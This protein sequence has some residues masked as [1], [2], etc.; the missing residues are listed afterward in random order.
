MSNSKTITEVEL[1]VEA[2]DDVPVD[3]ADGQAAIKRLG[4]DVKSWTAS[5]RA[6]VTE[7]EVKQRKVRFSEA[8]KEYT[9]EV[10]RLSARVAEPVRS[11]DEQR[12]RVKALLARAPRET[13]VSMHFHKFEQATAEELTEMIRSLRHLLGEDTDDHDDEG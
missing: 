11:V 10:E 12:R 4:I 1:L 2:L 7:A 6:K 3:D 8:T 5:V 9:A 13:A